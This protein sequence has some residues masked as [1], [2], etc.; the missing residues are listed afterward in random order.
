MV[1]EE[2]MA[3]GEAQTMGSA[4]YFSSLRGNSLSKQKSPK[5]NREAKGSCCRILG[6]KD[7][8]DHMIRSDSILE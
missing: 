3:A 8:S 6:A 4:L 1:L 7:V 2:V 5:A